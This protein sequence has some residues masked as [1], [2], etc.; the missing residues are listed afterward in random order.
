M[1][2]S[3]KRALSGLVVFIVGLA[4]VLGAPCNTSG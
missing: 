2:E 1:V 3:L 4:P